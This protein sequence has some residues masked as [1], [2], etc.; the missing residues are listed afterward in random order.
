MSFNSQPLE[1]G[2]V[3]RF[4]HGYFLG[5]FNSQPLEGGCAFGRFFLARSQLFQLTAARRRLR[6][7]WAS[8]R[9]SKKFQLTAARRRLLRLYADGLFHFRVS[10]HSRSK[11]AAFGRASNRYPPAYCFNSQPL[12]GGCKRRGAVPQPPGCVSTHSRSK[13]AARAGNDVCRSGNVSTHSRSKAA[14]PVYNVIAVPVEVSTHSRSKAAAQDKIKPLDY[15][16]FQLTAA[17]RR[18]RLLLE[19]G[20]NDGLVST[21]SRSK[22]AASGLCRGCQGAP[23]FNSQ[24]LEGGCVSISSTAILMSLFQLTAA[25]RRLPTLI[26]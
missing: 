22:A 20:L 14:A 15:K 16:M 8:I 3:I 7:T 2:C 1:G 12:E 26:W 24:P 13:A 4:V 25:R 11:A 21:H 6:T 9:W 23:G 10:T 5:C 19:Q 17:R 18:L